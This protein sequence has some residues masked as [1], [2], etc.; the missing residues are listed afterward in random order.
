MSRS[1]Y[2]FFGCLGQ[3]YM[4]KAEEFERKRLYECSAKNFEVAGECFGKAEEIAKSDMMQEHG[5]SALKKTY[6]QN[7]AKQMKEE[8]REQLSSV[9][10]HSNK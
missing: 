5:A 9:S 8:S 1:D 4:E 6:C 3:R 10:R 2:I 7:K